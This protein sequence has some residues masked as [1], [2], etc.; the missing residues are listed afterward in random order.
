M[1]RGNFEYNYPKVIKYLKDN[2]IEFIEY[3]NGQHL[4][5][6]GD[7]S[8][9]DLWPSRMT[10]HVIDS[11]NV[12]TSEDSGYSRL[13]IYFNPEQLGKILNGDS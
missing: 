7:V 9:V 13:D 12:I 4:R 2:D 1:S 6:M 11:E 10:Y 8:L 3:S 5:I